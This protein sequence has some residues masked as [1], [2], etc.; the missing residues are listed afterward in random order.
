MGDI[1]LKVPL[2][3]FP[4]RGCGQRN[5]ITDPG[6][7]VLDNTFDD[8]TLTGGITT[9]KYNHNFKPFLPYPFL[10]LDQFYLKPKQFF[11]VKLF[12]QFFLFLSSQPWIILMIRIHFFNYLFLGLGSFILSHNFLPSIV[13]VQFPTVLPSVYNYHE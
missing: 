4:F 3:F 8:P 5:Y 13:V 9:L 10:E 7:H 1:T 6:V 2:R 12:R 11:L